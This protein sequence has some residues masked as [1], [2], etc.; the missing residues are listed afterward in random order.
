ILLHLHDQRERFEHLSLGLRVSLEESLQK[1]EALLEKLQGEFEATRSIADQLVSA[2]ILDDLLGALSG[3]P[4]APA[5]DQA[6]PPEPTA[7]RPA[8]RDAMQLQSGH[9]ALDSLLEGLATE[10]GVDQLLLLDGPTP[11][12]GRFD[13][14]STQLADGLTVLEADLLE[15]GSSLDIGAARLLILELQGRI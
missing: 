4:S 7:A 10:R 8:Q 9:Q 11:A 15:L 14:T 12:A 2:H 13:E 6:G 5:T 1:A 3:P